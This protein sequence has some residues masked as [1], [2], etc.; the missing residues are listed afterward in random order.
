MYIHTTFVLPKG[1]CKQVY[2]CFLLLLVR[3]QLLIG[4]TTFVTCAF[5]YYLGQCEQRTYSSWTCNQNWG[6]FIDRSQ[7]KLDEP[8]VVIKTL[9]TLITI[10]YKGKWKP[11]GFAFIHSFIHSFIEVVW[12]FI[13][14]FHTFIQFHG[15]GFFFFGFPKIKTSTLCS[16]VE[17]LT[18][19]QESRPINVQLKSS[20]PIGEKVEISP[21]ESRLKQKGKKMLF[22]LP[23]V[24]N[25]C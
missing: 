23:Q 13:S 15:C 11:T 18:L 16:R 5:F 6:N 2:L 20:I 1:L 12:K 8:K 4:C 19:H 25:K 7:V 17:R 10:E 22:N 14:A 24:T 21:K 9:E 3:W